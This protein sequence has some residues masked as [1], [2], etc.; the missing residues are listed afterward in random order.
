VPIDRFAFTRLTLH[1]APGVLI[2]FAFAL[3][4]VDTHSKGAPTP[5][6]SKRVF[7]ELIVQGER[8]EIAACMA[9]A[10]AY[11]RRDAKFD[12]IR[13]AD[14]VSDSAYMRETEGGIH[15]SR[16]VRFNA[17]L[18][19]RTHGFFTETWTRAEIICEQRDEEAPEVRFALLK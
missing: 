1:I 9:A 8:P 17:H 11:V 7:R 3:T 10:V 13:W 18:R 12:A 15:V 5:L 4:A 19:D 6:H 2:G 14:D 16:T